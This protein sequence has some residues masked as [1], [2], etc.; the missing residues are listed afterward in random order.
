MFFI[1]KSCLTGLSVI[2][3]NPYIKRTRLP[4]LRFT[5]ILSSTTFQIFLHFK[6]MFETNDVFEVIDATDGLF[7]VALV[8][9]L[10]NI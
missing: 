6:K 3:L 1:I 8:S 5:L 7:K 4:S 10:C 2:G 9:N